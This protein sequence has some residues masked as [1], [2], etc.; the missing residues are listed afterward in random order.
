MSSS[1]DRADA[2]DT[3]TVAESSE[4][5]ISGMNDSAL[6]EQ[7]LVNEDI[8]RPAVHEDADGALSESD[9]SVDK[10]GEGGAG[11]MS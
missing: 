10:G 1:G 3:A 4:H 2:R 5:G 9:D 7:L 11:A 6:D 8:S